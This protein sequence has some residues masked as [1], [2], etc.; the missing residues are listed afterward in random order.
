VARRT[1]PVREIP[2]EA[3]LT[4]YGEIFPDAH[5]SFRNRLR[6]HMG[7][8]ELSLI[9]GKKSSAEAAQ[10]VTRSVGPFASARYTTAGELRGAGFIVRHSPSPTRPLH[11][12]VHPPIS[13]NQSAEWDEPMA[14]L[15]DKCFT[16][17]MGGEERHE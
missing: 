5:E 3:I 11:V 15:F 10:I 14:E 13:G 4:Q 8:N 17:A 12:S 2:A 16:S 6:E 1:A 7:E 9:W